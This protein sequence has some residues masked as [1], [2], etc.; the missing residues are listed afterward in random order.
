M[1]VR[2]VGFDIKKFNFGE[3]IEDLK[4]E[5]SDSEEFELTV[6]VDTRK[7]RRGLRKQTRELKYFFFENIFIISI[8]LG[9][10]IIVLGVG[11][12]LNFEVY[13]KVYKE[14]IA[15]KTQNFIMKINDSY[16]THNNYLGKSIAPKNKEY[17]IVN[18]NIKSNNA[19]NITLD[20]EKVSLVLSNK[21]YYPILGKYASFFDLGVGYNTQKIDHSPNNYIFVFEI[22]E[23]SYNYNNAIFRYIESTRISSNKVETRYKKVKLTPESLDTNNVVATIKKG[24]KMWL[25]QSSLKASTLIIN[26]IEINKSFN[27]QVTSCINSVCSDIQ[28]TISADIYTTKDLSILHIKDTY[29]SDKSAAYLEINNFRLLINKFGKLVYTINNKNYELAI[30]DY[31]PND[32][33]GEDAYIEVPGYI[34]NATSIKLMLMLRNKDYI[35]IL[36]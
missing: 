5:A 33:Q 11:L 8:I 25:G 4:I 17:I 22:D 19:E 36:K 31:T 30:N 7:I 27:Y 29:T 20:P 15:F 2:A 18:F 23:S 21:V 14:E 34:T 28:K 12:Y 1:T 32:Y 9:I 35:Y 26:D 24:E 13:N 6:G 3:D 16:I 10:F